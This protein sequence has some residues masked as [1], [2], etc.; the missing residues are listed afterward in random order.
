LEELLLDEA[1]PRATPPPVAAPPLLAPPL[2]GFPPAVALT[3]LVA[4][5]PPL[6]APP[7]GATD[8]GALPPV[9]LRVVRLVL[10][11]DPPL[12]ARAVELRW[13]EPSGIDVPPIA[14]AAP[15]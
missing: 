7:L 8:P 6:A 14:V 13:D 3:V 10:F 15:P 11:S 1:P 9:E 12:D 2:A 4:D 5:L